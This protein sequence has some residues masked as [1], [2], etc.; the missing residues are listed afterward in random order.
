MDDK[1]LESFEKIEARIIKS[2]QEVQSCKDEV[3]KAKS[4]IDAI[5]QE[6]LI[7]RR[8]L[9][10]QL[11]KMGV[12]KNDSLTEIK[13]LSDSCIKTIHGFDIGRMKKDISDAENDIAKFKYDLENIAKLSKEASKSKSDIEQYLADLKKGKKDFLN[14]FIYPAA[15]FFLILNIAIALLINYRANNIITN[16]QSVLVDEH[17]NGVDRKMNGIIE[18]LYDK[19]IMVSPDKVIIK[20]EETKPIKK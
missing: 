7:N 3:L 9:N 11:D 18:A 16:N 8:E 15:V 6:A 14:Y 2:Y 12:L 19:G 20:K 10:E 1:K 17:I 4:A 13:K 5:M